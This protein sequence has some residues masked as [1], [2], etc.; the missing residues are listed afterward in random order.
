MGYTGPI[1]ANL[2]DP[3]VAEIASERMAGAGQDALH[4]M[5]VMNTPVDDNPYRSHK[6]PPRG[7]T[8]RRWV[9]E[10]INRHRIVS[11]GAADALTM[12]YD[13]AVVNR[14]EWI[15]ALE[16]G[17]GLW[18]PRHARYPIRPKPSNPTGRLAWRDRVTGHWH[19]A[20][21]VMHP[22]IHGQHMM[23]TAVAYVDHVAEH[24]LAPELH[25]WAHE[26]EAH[27]GRAG[28]IVH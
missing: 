10:P 21:L 20:K 2:F 27:F 6:K 4:T 17:S 11:A 1:L 25:R 12:A 22:G 19:S 18:G 15:E 3:L 13:G 5:A 7:E 23:G 14:V 24:V 16:S 28:K 9:K 26:Q 8:R